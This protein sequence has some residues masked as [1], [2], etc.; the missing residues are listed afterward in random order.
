VFRLEGLPA[1]GLIEVT[2]S[3]PGFLDFSDERV[4][5][6]TSNLQVALKWRGER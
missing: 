4:S 5:V 3:C 1:Q 6:N 2:V